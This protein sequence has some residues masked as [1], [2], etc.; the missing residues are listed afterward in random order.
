MFDALELAAHIAGLDIDSDP[1]V[2]EVEEV[3]LDRHDVDFD[4]F[5]RMVKL[6]IPYTHPI[7]SPLS[8]TSYHALGYADGKGWLALCKTPAAIAK[9]KGDD[10]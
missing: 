3:L 5:E 10:E 2:F 4:T 8:G 7:Q 9:A 1:D 6:L